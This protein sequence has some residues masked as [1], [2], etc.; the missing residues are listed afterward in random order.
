MKIKKEKLFEDIEKDIYEQRR[1][2][3]YRVI[4]KNIKKKFTESKNINEFIRKLKINFKEKDTVKLLKFRNN[5]EFVIDINKP[6]WKNTKAFKEFISKFPRTEGI[7]ELVE[8]WKIFFE[9][10]FNNYE[11]KELY[12]R[13]TLEWMELKEDRMLLYKYFN[14][15]KE[16]IKNLNLSNVKILYGLDVNLVKSNYDMY[17]ILFNYMNY[18]KKEILN[19]YEDDNFK[20]T[21]IEVFKHISKL[22]NGFKTPL[23]IKKYYYDKIYEK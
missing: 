15:R 3:S 7:Y 6:H 1:F 13:I 21:D 8:T 12:R 9:T 10:V 23:T 22:T 16:Q 14:S 5:I 11:A 17:P 19:I 20:T 2:E 18:I 4:E